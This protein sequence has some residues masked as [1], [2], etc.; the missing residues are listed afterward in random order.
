MTL[1][2]RIKTLRKNL[3][4]TQEKLA[5]IL[6]I[7]PQAISRWETDVAMPDISLLPAL[8]N[9]FGMTTDYLLGMEDYQKNNRKARYDLAYKDYWKC[10]DKESNY[11]IALEAVNEYPGNMEYVEWLAST[12]YFIGIT[13][14]GD[15]F[16]QYLQNSVKHY[17]IVVDNC[18]K[19][20]IY[21]KALNGIVLALNMLGKKEDAKKYA[22]MHDDEEKRD[23]M[24]LWCT[25]GMERTKLVQK[26]TERY[27][28]GFL[29]YI[30]FSDN[31]IDKCDAI[32]KVLSTLFPDGNYQYYHN[33]IQ[34]SC[35]EKAM[36]L[37]ENKRY[38]EAIVTL[39]K[40][41]YHS[42]EMVKY[43]QQP[44]FIF[45]SPLFNMLTGEKVHNNL[46]S[47]AIDVFISCINNNVAFDP[48]RDNPEVI[49]LLKK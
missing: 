45:T 20:K 42:E 26:I 29:C 48:V 32:E 2:M 14:S 31:K 19:Q 49:E 34:F 13:K 36:V 11:H 8:S 22:T 39:K 44:C 47:N 30:T 21:D 33:I 7:S 10:Y 18:D 28:N 27:L 40:A 4:L 38:D 6:S 37:C 25:S 17:K 24:L 9:L 46:Q 23:E 16:S 15:E 43:D 5:E 1:G 12:E 35:L 3:N 41:R